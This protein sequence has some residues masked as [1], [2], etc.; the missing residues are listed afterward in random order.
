MRKI[1]H[2]DHSSAKIGIKRLNSS[3]HFILDIMQDDLN[4]FGWRL[5]ADRGNQNK[6]C[7]RSEWKILN[8]SAETVPA[9]YFSPTLWIL[10]HVTASEKYSACSMHNAKRRQAKEVEQMKWDNM[11]KENNYTEIDRNQ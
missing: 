8:G 11:E 6:L 9:P 10:I 1:S 5:Y 4:Y 2:V 3:E 7:T